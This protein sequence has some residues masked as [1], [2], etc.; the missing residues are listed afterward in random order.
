MGVYDVPTPFLLEAVA[1]DLK[2]H[3]KVTQPAFALFVK[4]GAQAERAPQDPDWYFT[5]CASILYRVF[6]DGPVGTESLRTYYGGRKS[7]GVKPHKH[8]KAG[9]KIIRLALQ[10]LEKS[11]L[12]KKGEKGGRTITPLGQKYLNEMSKLAADAAKNYVKKKRVFKKGSKTDGDVRDAL[13][14]GGGKKDSDKDDKGGKHDD[15]AK[16]KKEGSDAE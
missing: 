3:K 8:Y 16:K 11:A 15:K 10:Q 1:K 13:K 14:K 12:V 9:G 4:T 7:R 6:K 5:R 2:E